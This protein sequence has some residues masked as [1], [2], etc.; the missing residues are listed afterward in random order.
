MTK[1]PAVL[2]QA[3]DEGGFLIFDYVVWP[4]PSFVKLRMR[5]GVSGNQS[6][7]HKKTTRLGGGC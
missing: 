7:G 4:P 3:Q 2:R 5:A 6:I 1:A